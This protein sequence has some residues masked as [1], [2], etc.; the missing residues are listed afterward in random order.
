MQRVAHGLGGEAPILD[1]FVRDATIY[2]AAADGTIC[3]WRADGQPL[4]R[5][6]APGGLAP[7]R[8]VDVRGDDVI[9]WGWE[10][11]ERRALDT[12]ARRWAYDDGD[13][14]LD[15]SEGSCAV[16]ER[17]ALLPNGALLDLDDG[18]F[19]WGPELERFVSQSDGGA[20]ASTPNGLIAVGYDGVIRRWHPRAGVELVAFT[21]GTP[22][23][24]AWTPARGE[25]LVA[26]QAGALV[27][28]ADGATFVAGR[29]PAPRGE[30]CLLASNSH[31]ALYEAARPVGV[32]EPQVCVS[33]WRL[34]T[35]E[36]VRVDQWSGAYVFPAACSLPFCYRE[37]ELE[38]IGSSPLT[39]H[40]IG[41]TATAACVT[42][43]AVVVG[44]VDGRLDFYQRAALG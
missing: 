43:R 30:V 32:R 21:A 31:V 20:F 34:D 4:H 22:T 23:A 40:A 29:P 16:F 35:R 36:L 10:C 28:L 2:S 27:S 14:S 6:E 15:E 12:G 9:T 13:H 25:L 38:L 5:Y 33:W 44:H 8:L 26:T 1:I 17:W 37:G 19:A 11:V 42:R 41:D 18:E 3:A 39:T 7:C 24:A